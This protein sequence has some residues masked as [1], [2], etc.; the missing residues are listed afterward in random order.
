LP[1]KDH[2]HYYHSQDEAQHLHE[3]GE[4]EEVSDADTEIKLVDSEL[5]HIHPPVRIRFYLEL[6][7]SFNKHPKMADADMYI[8]ELDNNETLLHDDSIAEPVDSPRRLRPRRKRVSIQDILPQPIRSNETE[9]IETR[10][11]KT[12]QKRF[13]WRTPANKYGIYR[14]YVACP[15]EARLQQL[16][17]GSEHADS[18]SDEISLHASLNQKLTLTQAL[19]PFTNMSQFLWTRWYLGNPQ[20][21][22][23]SQHSDHF[24]KDVVCHP[25]FESSDLEG[26]SMADIREA[27]ANWNP[28][29]CEPHQG[30]KSV[31]VAI[32]VPLGKPKKGMSHPLSA[33]FEVPNLQVRSIV[34]IVRNV[35]AHDDN[36]KDFIWIPYREYQRDPATGS[37][38]TRIFDE[39]MS[40]DEVHRLWKE[41]QKCPGVPGCMAE[42]VVLFLRFWSD[43][44]HLAQFGN[45][46]LWPFYMC[47]A[48][49]PKWQCSDPNMGAW[50]DVAY[51]QQVCITCC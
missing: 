17:H 1:Q 9:R 20:G 28:S 4:E 50:H 13:I 24:T 6:V 2:E 35:L 36:V 19:L 8:P 23:S 25:L 30:W 15:F 12:K 45:H 41:V 43:S 40:G 26:T 46:K 14:D 22:M 51:F 47:F 32:D 27:V 49:Q 38:H 37:I 7:Q 10:R 44:T 48:N 3:E 42:R 16:A 11:E 34:E 21:G 33:S 39:A 5:D 18:A 31:S 29:P